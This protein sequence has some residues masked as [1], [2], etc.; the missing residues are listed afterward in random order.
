MR[1]ITEFWPILAITL[2][3]LPVLFACANE[4]APDKGKQLYEVC[5]SCH[6]AA[7]NGREAVKAPALAGLD[8]A[9]LRKQLEHFA[10]EKRGAIGTDAYGPQMVLLSRVLGGDDERRVV[11]DYIAALKPTQSRGSIN[12]DKEHGKT[13]YATCASCHGDRAQGSAEIG[14]PRLT[15]QS[16]WYLVL[17]LQNYRDGKRGYAADDSAGQQMGQ[18]AKDLGDDAAIRDVVAYVNS[19]R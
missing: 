3:F 9:Y 12:G 2:G 19:L 10:L 11:A 13:L 17:Q 15:G 8:S 18:I 7:A 14:A 16:D 4:P 6:G 5:V 1:N